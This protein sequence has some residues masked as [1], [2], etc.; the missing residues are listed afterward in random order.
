[1]SKGVKIRENIFNEFSQNFSRVMDNPHLKRTIIGFY[2]CPLCLES[3]TEYHLNQS[4]ENPLTIEDVP[5][6]KL[7][8]KPLLLTCKK[9]NNLNGSIYDSELGKW[10]KAY[11]VLEGK[12]EFDFKMS[13]DSSRTF[14][15]KLVRDIDNKTTSI[16]SN[17]KNPYAEKNVSKMHT[18]G[19]AGVNFLFDFGDDKKI[20]DG[21]LRFAYLYAFYHFGYAYI[22]SP[23]GKYVKDYLVLNKSQELKPLIISKKLEDLD[24]GI[25]KISY[26][27]D[28]TSF[29]V[30]FKLGSEIV[31]N[32]GVILPGPKEEHIENFKLID[33][34]RIGTLKFQ[35][36]IKQDINDKPF[37]CY[38]IWK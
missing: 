1:M 30:V 13:I 19:K 24:Q 36:I 31:K 26:P 11:C 16:N 21:F 20:D 6:K 18:Q 4:V 28:I 12:G 9:C 37:V 8:G 17:T 27:T 7:N 33:K 25:Y 29:L 3:F 5:P 2:I 35:Q 32:I 10:F 34:K 22:F 23:G 14:K 15:A 38:Q